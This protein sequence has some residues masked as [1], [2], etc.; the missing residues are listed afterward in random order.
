MKLKIFIGSMRWISLSICV[1]LFGSACSSVPVQRSE[2]MGFFEMLAQGRHGR[3][4]D[5][6]R[7]VESYETVTSEEEVSSVIPPKQMKQAAKNLNFQW[8]LQSVAISSKF[9]P[10]ERDFHEG[11]DLRAKI[12]T[13][14]FASQSGKVIYSGRGI[15]GYGKM[16]VIKHSGGFATVYAHN[17]KIYVKE[18]QRVK[19]GQKIALSGNTGRTSGPHLHFEVRKGVSAIDPLRVLPRKDERIADLRK[20]ARF[21]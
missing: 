3:S 8:P 18:G 5:E 13:A 20:P 6:L 10:R 7:E 9:G 11:I 21:K 4:A 19:Q 12:G 17:S 1:V 2:R 14:V 15:S 16:L